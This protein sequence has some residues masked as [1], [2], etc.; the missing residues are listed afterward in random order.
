MK[1]PTLVI[2]AAGMGSRYGG[3]KQIDPVDNHG[4]KIIDFSIYDAVRAGFKKVIFIIKKENLE[5]FKTCI[6]DIVKD[7][8]E[9]EYVFQELTN[10]PDGFSV[11]E[12][13]VK[14]WGTAHAVL[15]AIESVDGPF[16]VINADDFYGREAFAKIYDYLTST[17]DDE[18]YRYA[19]VGYKL[20]NTLTENG[21]VSRGVCSTDNNGFLTDIEE[22]T[23]IVKTENG[24]AFTDDEVNYNDISP[25]TIVSMNMWG[26]QKSFMAELKSAFKS[27]V[28]K[29]VPSNPMKAECYL[30][31]VV[32]D[33]IKA[34]KATVKVLTSSDKWFGVTYKED[35]PFVV[36]SIQALKDNGAYPD[37]LW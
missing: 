7:H 28:E 25:E 23:K 9:V 10:I 14:P 13:R 4:N 29:D 12:E 17:V 18:K 36:E 11:P 1:A 22:K 31:F 30:P 24:A 26:F 27:F 8:I 20:I 21:S 32:D 6:G 34:D 3:L 19:M 16:A 15:S 35:K 37:K 2:M 33:L 5:D